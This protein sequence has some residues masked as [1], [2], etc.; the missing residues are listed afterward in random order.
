MKLS[1]LKTG[2][3]IIKDAKKDEYSYATTSSTYSMGIYSNGALRSSGETKVF[4]HGVAKKGYGVRSRLE[5]DGGLPGQAVLVADGF[6]TSHLKI[7]T[8]LETGRDKLI[9]VVLD[10]RYVSS[11]SLSGEVDPLSVHLDQ[12][13]P[14]TM[15]GTFNFPIVGTTQIKANGSGASDL[16]LVTGA[17][18]TLLLDT[19]VWDDL[20]ITPGSFDR[21]GVSDPTYQV[22]QPAGSG[23]SFYVLK[24]NQSQYADFTVQLPHGYKAGTSIYVHA[25]WTPGD[26]GT[27]EGTHTVAWKLAYTWGNIGAVFGASAVADMTDACESTNDQHL[28][29]PEIEISGAGKTISSMIMCRIYRDTGDSWAGTA[30]NGPAL[31]EVDFHYSLDTIGSRLASA[32]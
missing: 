4:V 29:T 17:A 12:T 16:T 1:Q 32:K 2:Y 26:R 7:G 28:M 18:K 30:A 22:W 5:G 31:L 27:T 20:R 9:S 6:T 10:I 19:V 24:F 3:I 14:Q 13:I 23:V 11:V 8:A 25:H 15:V 21:P